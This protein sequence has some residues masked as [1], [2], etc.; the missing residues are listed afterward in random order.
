MLP[1]WNKLQDRKRKLET[2]TGGTSRF[3]H[4]YTTLGQ[5]VKNEQAFIIAWLVKRSNANEDEIMRTKTKD[6]KDGLMKLVTAATQLQAKQRLTTVHVDMELTTAVLDKCHGRYGQRLQD[7]Q[8]HIKEDG[9]VAWIPPI[10][11]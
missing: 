9:E 4:V 1:L 6:T 10:T 5:L 7:L 8:K 3:A 2:S 11:Y